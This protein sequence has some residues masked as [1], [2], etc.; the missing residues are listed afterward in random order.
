VE[1]EQLLNT[2]TIARLL[3]RAE[4][5]ASSRIEGL[6]ISARKLLRLQAAREAG[7]ELQDVTAAE[8]LGNIDAMVHGIA[9]SGVGKPISLEALCEVHARLLAG[10]RL[11]AHG[12]KL[13]RVQNWIGGSAY[14]PRGA[15]FVPPPPEHVEDLCRDLCRFCD[16]DDLPAVA[17]AALAHA[18]FETIHPFAD[19]NGRTGRALVHLVLRRRGLVTAVLPPVSLILATSS[20]DYIGGLTAT[21]YVGPAE[22]PAAQDGM[23]LWIERFATACLRAVDDVGHYRER[24]TAIRSE[25]STRLARVRAG[26]ASSLLLDL[27]LSVPVITVHSAAKMIGRTFPATNNAVAALVEAGILKQTS[28]GRRNR[29]FEAPDVLSAFNALERRLASPAGD[30][31]MAKPSRRTPAAQ[32]DWL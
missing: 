1:A 19:G 9:I 26:S 32:K 23:N 6:E 29:A 5:V 13:R 20:K 27:L 16:S 3:L 21:R 30:T 8:V 4:S 17:Q 15:A 11:A 25:W 7:E 24:A 10:T 12:G 18:Q 28:L 14:S 22:A 2:E 31:R